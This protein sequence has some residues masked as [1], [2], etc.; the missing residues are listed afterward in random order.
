LLNRAFRL[1]VKKKRLAARSRPD[2]ELPPEDP[3]AIREGFFRRADVERLC[4]P[5]DCSPLA[6]DARSWTL[7]T[8]ATQPEVHPCWHLSAGLAGMV[9]FLFFCPWRIGAARKLEWRD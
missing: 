5:C 4:A 2:I 7:A 6:V 3:N 1:A 9:H 8:R